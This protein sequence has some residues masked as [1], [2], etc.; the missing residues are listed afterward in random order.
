MRQTKFNSIWF[1]KLKL[2]SLKRKEHISDFSNTHISYMFLLHVLLTYM[3]LKTSKINT[4]IPDHALQKKANNSAHVLYR[5]VIFP[6]KWS[7]EVQYHDN[8][9]KTNLKG[10]QYLV[11]LFIYNFNC[12]IEW[13]VSLYARS[14]LCLCASIA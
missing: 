3:T 13:S 9:Y 12:G 5:S 14:S 6:Y 8:E 1:I 4:K 11:G 2:T 10:I 7:F